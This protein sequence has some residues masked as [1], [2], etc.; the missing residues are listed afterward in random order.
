MA[1]SLKQDFWNWFQEN[2]ATYLGILKMNKKETCYWMEKAL[3]QLRLCGTNLSPRF[4][5]PSDG[6]TP[7]FIITAGGKRQ[8]FKQVEG[9]IVE[10]PPIPGWEIIGFLPPR[11]IDFLIEEQ[12]RHTGIEPHNLWFIPHLLGYDKKPWTCVF[13][14]RHKMP[15]KAFKNAVNAVVLNLLGEHSFTLNLDRI[16]VKRWVDVIPGERSKFLKLQELPAYIERTRFSSCF[17]DEQWL[18]EA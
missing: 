10:A 5:I 2:Q 15:D 6:S 14:D 12:H 1:F 18:M 3:V 17:S 9:L 11:P 7:Q 13:A 16:T 8:Y 4:F